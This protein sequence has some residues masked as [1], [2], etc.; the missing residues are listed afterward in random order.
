MKPLGGSGLAKSDTTLQI[1][2]PYDTK[3]QLRLR[4]AET[5]DPVRVLVLKALKQAGYTIPSATMVDRRKGSAG[6]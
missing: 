4:S 6:Q 2:I 5:G 1:D 3:K